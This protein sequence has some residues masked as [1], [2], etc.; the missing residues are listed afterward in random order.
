MKRRR[1]GVKSK[2]RRTFRKGGIKAEHLVKKAKTAA[3]GVA[4]LTAMQRA[5][6]LLRQMTIEEK[7]MQLSSIFPLALFT[8]KGVNRSQLDALLKNGIGH[9]SAIGLIGYKTSEL[10]AKLINAVLRR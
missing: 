3:K 8:T 6:E 10:M 7:A 2:S 1:R 9:I 4:S 5:E